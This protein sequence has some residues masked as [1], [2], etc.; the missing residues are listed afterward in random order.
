MPKPRSRREVV[1]RCSALRTLVREAL[2]RLPEGA[3]DPA[4]VESAWQA[5]GLGTLLWALGR[6]DLP[7]YDRRF[8]HDRVLAA[9]L[10]GAV[11]RPAEEL[12]RAR[13]TARLWHWRARTSALLEASALELPY[14][15]QSFEQLIAATAMRAHERGL[16]PPPLRGDFAAFGAVYRDL[17]EER[18]AEAE[19]IAWER[20]RALNWVC[21]LGRS[22]D[23]V[24]LDT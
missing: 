4:V 19:S 20:H 21:G 18:L 7:P 24:P 5:E 17:P 22:W 13:E 2:A 16:L 12:E 9:P 6:A 11:L 23:D 10:H 15:W 14:R 8:A 1:D 3:S